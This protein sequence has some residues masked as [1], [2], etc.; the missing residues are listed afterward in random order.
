MIKSED[1]VKADFE[2]LQSALVKYNSYEKCL[3]A[4][5]K[6]LVEAMEHN[7][8]C[9]IQKIFKECGVPSDQVKPLIKWGIDCYNQQ[10]HMW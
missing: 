2:Y 5:A 10:Y 4:H 3:Q 7:D 8:F 9:A 1:K 6:E